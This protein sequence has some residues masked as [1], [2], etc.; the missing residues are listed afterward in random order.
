M[1]GIELKIQILRKSISTSTSWL[2][3]CDHL[4]AT[5]PKELD[6]C[7]QTRLRELALEFKVSV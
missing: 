4:L 6:K 7:D 3:G 5:I 1:A 2:D